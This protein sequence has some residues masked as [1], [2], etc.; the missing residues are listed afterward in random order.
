MF[1]RRNGCPGLISSTTEFAFVH[2]CFRSPPAQGSS[3]RR[4]RQRC[5]AF[6]RLWSAEPNSVSNAIAYALHY[7]CS[8]PVVIRVYDAAGNV[9]E[10]HER[11]GRIKAPLCGCLSSST[12]ED[13]SF[14]LHKNCERS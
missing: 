10:T 14:N 5:A 11:K 1:I 4:S 3:R 7:S 8:H 2:S 9:I 13:G 6:R 12:A